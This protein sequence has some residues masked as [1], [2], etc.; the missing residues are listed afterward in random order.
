MISLTNQLVKSKIENFISILS[1]LQYEIIKILD[2][3]GPMTRIEI[4]KQ[5]KCAR[6]TIYDNLIRLERL[7]ILHKFNKSNGM[8]G[9]PL[10][11]WQLI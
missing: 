7:N 1:P 9:R 6:T 8:I 11:Y 4:V 5:L 2:Y 10:V 3:N